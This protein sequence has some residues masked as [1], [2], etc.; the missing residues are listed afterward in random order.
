MG[1]NRAKRGK[2][3]QIWPNR[4]KRGQNGAKQGK[5]EPNRIMT[6]LRIVNFFEKI[7]VL[8]IFT[9]IGMATILIMEII[10]WDCDLKIGP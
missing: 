3:G 4:V 9:I 1:P 5:T 7:L 2:W 6:I 10:I 8:W